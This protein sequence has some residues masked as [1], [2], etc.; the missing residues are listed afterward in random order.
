MRRE[1][2]G[3]LRDADRAAARAAAHRDQAVLLRAA[4]D[5]RHR[6]RARR[7]RVAG[8]ADALRGADAAAGD[9]F[10]AT[11]D[12]GPPARR[13]RPRAARPARPTPPPSPP[14]RPS[15]SRLT[16]T[17][18]ARR[19]PARASMALVGTGTERGTSALG[20]T[21][22]RSRRV[23]CSTDRHGRPGDRR[24]GVPRTG[25]GGRGAAA[26]RGRHRLQPRQVRRDAPTARISSSVTARSTP[27][28]N[29]CA[30]GHFDVVV[31][32]CGYVP[33][34]VARSANVLAGSAD[35][36]AFVSSINAYPGWPEERGLHR[37]RPARR[38]TRTRPATTCPT[39]WIPARPTAGS[40]SAAS[41]RWPAR[42]GRTGP[43]CCAAGRSS[44]PTTAR[45]AG[46]RGGSTG[47]PAAARC[48]CPGARRLRRAH[49]RARLARFALTGAPGTFETPGPSGRDTRADLMA[50]CRGGDRR[51]RD[52]HLRR[53]RV[54]RRAGASRRGPRSRSG[55]PR[56]RRP[57]V[58]AHHSEDAEAAG[59]TWRPLAET[60]ADTW[61][62]QQTVAGGWQPSK[63]HAR[64]AAGP[65]A[66]TARRLAQ[67][68]LTTAR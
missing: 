6:R 27:T 53:R 31:D 47:S 5:D 41:W 32:T 1:Q 8:V 40:R 7:H 38:Q 48:S 50:A 49:R 26:G 11:D 22:C 64:A 17:T 10:R 18:A 14:A 12:G 62:W 67:R 65:R 63:S 25:G 33:A 2:I 16:A 36:Y 59:L 44:G 29:S 57:G 4:Q 60:V 66:R 45:S 3:Y 56:P 34:E 58:F 35:H 61:A 51:R 52:V 54:A 20:E 37:A 19:E 68:R 43:P 21:C 46:C 42:S 28:S 39:T 55:C 15:P 30:A 13:S 23:P 24:L 9:G